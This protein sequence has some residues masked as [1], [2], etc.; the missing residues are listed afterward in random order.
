MTNIN[1]YKKGGADYASFVERKIFQNPAEEL[2]ILIGEY[3][4]GIGVGLDLGTGTGVL[5]A[6]A[7]KKFNHQLTLYGLDASENMLRVARNRG[8]QHLIH[9]ELPNIPFLE[10]TFDFVAA[11]FVVA[12]IAN[13]QALLRNIHHVL[14]AN[15]HFVF[16]SW[17]V[18]NKEYNEIWMDVLSQY[19]S[20]PHLKKIAQGLVP[21]EGKFSAKE[22][23]IKELEKSNTFFLVKHYTKH[24][25]NTMK[26][27]VY[28]Q[29]RYSFLMGKYL[30]EV[31]SDQL[32]EAFKDN[33]YKRFEAEFGTTIETTQIVHFFAF[34]C[35]K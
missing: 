35:E 30:R 17:G 29:C 10:D 34:S 16:T 21:H 3:F 12:H 25:K 23:V 28:L 2:S 8:F 18:S 7:K 5:L 6:E 24:Y 22:S 11:N 1:L 26:L 13:T 9:A 32:W 14:K 4:N 20:L 19:L 33:M 27:Q 15:G 31:M